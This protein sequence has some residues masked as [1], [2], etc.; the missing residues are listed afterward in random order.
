M[1]V[2]V[3]TVVVAAVALWAWSA[4]A[5]LL[6]DETAPVAARLLGGVALRLG[7]LVLILAAVALGIEATR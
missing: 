1:T 3:A 4:G 7:G 5:A 2:I 6:D